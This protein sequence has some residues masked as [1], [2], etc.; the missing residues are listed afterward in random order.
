ME[1]SS[2]TLLP[3]VLPN[4]LPSALVTRGQVR[5]Y[6]RRPAERRIRST[7]AVMFPHWSL[8]PSCASQ[9]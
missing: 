3:S 4:L 5:P 2:H 8:P 9:P 1:P 7:P 6:A